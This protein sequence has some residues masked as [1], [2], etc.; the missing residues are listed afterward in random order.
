MML[1]LPLANKRV[2]AAGVEENA[3]QQTGASSLLTPIQR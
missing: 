2:N 3:P 1:S